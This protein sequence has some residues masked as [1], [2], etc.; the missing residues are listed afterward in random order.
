MERRLYKTLLSIAQY[1]NHHLTPEQIEKLFSYGQLL[2][3]QNRLFNLTG[4]KTEAEIFENIICEAITMVT[5]Q[6]FEDPNT[7]V[8]DVGSG[9]GIPGIPLSILFPHLSLTFIE[10][11]AKKCGF[12]SDVLYRLQLPKGFIVCQRAETAGRVDHLRDTFDIGISRALASTAVALELVSPF[13]RVGGS[14]VFVK[15]PRIFEELQVSRD[16]LLRL[17][18]AL[19]RL[20]AVPLPGYHRL[21]YYAVVRKNKVTPPSYPRRVGIPQKRPLSC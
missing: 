19:E 15:G 18:C 13:V 1:Y 6:E 20:F 10:S 17:E 12:I 11:N 5:L 16:A 8:V 2:K 21:I 7:S 4:F 9:A 3:E 14:A